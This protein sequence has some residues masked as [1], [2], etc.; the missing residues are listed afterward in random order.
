MTDKIQPI[1]FAQLHA[2]GKSWG[3]WDKGDKGEVFK[4]GYEDALLSRTDR[5]YLEGIERHVPILAICEPWCGDV[6]RQLPILAKMCEANPKLDLRII[7]RDEHP[8]VMVRYLTNGAE[9]IPVFIFFNDEFVEVGSWLARPSVCR[10][11]LARAKAAGEL[12]KG[13]EAVGH[14]MD[15]T[16]NRLT[17]EELKILMDRA[18]ATPGRWP[19]FYEDALDRLTPMSSETILNPRN[20]ERVIDLYHCDDLVEAYMIEAALKDAGVHFFLQMFQ[21][22]VWDGLLEKDKGAAVVQVLEEDAERALEI[23]EQTV[24]LDEDDDD[25]VEEEEE[26]R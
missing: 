23:I 5:E 3:E 25:E 22:R 15:Q 11:I 26:A 4:D 14:I 9:S 13:K 19:L 17:V 1:D 18:L 10:Q 21:D 6:Q 20:Y 8:E 2:A 16:A 24:M 7:N 12:D